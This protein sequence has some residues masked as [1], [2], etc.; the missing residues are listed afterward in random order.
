MVPTEL[1]ACIIGSEPTEMLA[2]RATVASRMT[3][4]RFTDMSGRPGI[5]DYL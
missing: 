5:G 2:T 3:S 4:P 1:H